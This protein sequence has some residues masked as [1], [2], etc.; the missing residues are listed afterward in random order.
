MHAVKLKPK[1]MLVED[2]RTM[3]SLL[4]V[5]L[6]IEGY[7]VVVWESSQA[8]LSEA[9]ILSEIKIAR[10]DLLLL[11]AHV[12]DINGLNILR[13]LRADELNP[14]DVQIKD[15]HILVSSG[16]DLSDECSAEKADAFILKP[17]MP[18]ELIGL[19]HK[20]LC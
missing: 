6:E 19:I 8:S 7:N 12:Y 2:D 11:D 20:I 13:Q 1:V 5:L 3:A 10:P 15:I 16:L 14:K 17:Y 18:D 9:D 4:R